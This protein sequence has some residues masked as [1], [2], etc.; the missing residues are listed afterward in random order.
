M[1]PEVSFG[2]AKGGRCSVGSIPS[3]DQIIAALHLRAYKELKPCHIRH[4]RGSLSIRGSCNT[5]LPDMLCQQLTRSLMLQLCDGATT[6]ERQAWQL[7]EAKEYHYLNQSSCFQLKDMDNAA[8][9]KVLES[10]PLLRPCCPFKAHSRQAMSVLG[11][12]ST[13][14]RYC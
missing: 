12:T 7:G 14:R 2:E 8:E 3:F 11:V 13:A 6:A 10:P 4:L 9:Y 1:R 5:Y